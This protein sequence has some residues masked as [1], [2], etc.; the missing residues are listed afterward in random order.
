MK[1]TSITL[2]TLTAAAGFAQ[3]APAAASA[4]TVTGNVALT[5]NYVFRG[6]TQTNGHAAIQGGFDLTKTPVSGLTAG[7]WASNVD[8]GAKAGTEA[9]LYANYAFKV[10]AVDVSVGYIDYTYSA[11]SG[12]ATGAEANV[13][14]TYAGL[15]LKVSKGVDG[16]LSDYYYEANYSYDIAAIKGL[17][18]GLHYGSD[19]ASKNNDYGVALNYPIA[20]LDTSVSYTDIQKGKSVTAFTVKKSF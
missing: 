17:N 5:S 20:G 18:L 10:S 4:F 3:S 19:R 8:T 9:D 11:A 7:V 15:T 1:H 14:A 12:L 13:S 16:A 2:L 6:L